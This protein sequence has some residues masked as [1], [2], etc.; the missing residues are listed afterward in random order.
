MIVRI[1]AIITFLFQCVLSFAQIDT[2]LWQ[3]CLGTDDGYNYTNAVEKCAEGYLFGI[4]L[5]NNGPDISNFHGGA[6]SWIVNTD[7]V[8]N[9]IWERCYGGSKGDGPEKIIK[10]DESYFYLLNHSN[11]V[12][13]DILNGRGGNFWVVKINA[14]GNIIWENSFGGSVYGEEVRDAI[15]MPNKGLLLMGRITSS[16]GDVT[17]YYGMADIWFCK[18]D[19][20]GAIEWEKTYGNQGQDNALKL[21]LTSNNTVLMIGGHE[22][23]GGMIDC[24]DPGNDGADVWI[25]QMDLNGNMLNQWCFGGRHHDLGWDIIE[26]ENGYVFAA[27]TNSN[28][29]DVNG[30]HGSEW[31][32]YSDIWVVKI[33]FSGNLIWQ[34]CLGGYSWEYPVYL[35]Q[36]GD[37]GFII[38]GN[39]CS[40]D[41]DVT[42]NHSLY[43]IYADIWV[44]KVNSDGQ[45]EW[46]HCFGGGSVE[47]FF[48]IH[49]VL[50]RDDYNYVL[51]A[52]ADYLDGDVE[53]DLFPNDLQDNAWLLEIKDCNF[54][55]P[56]APA[57]SSGPDT[58]CSINHATSIYSINPVTWSWGYEWSIEPENAGILLQHS[59]IVEITWN[60]QFE[61]PVAITARSYNDCGYSNWS[62][63]HNTWI[64][65]CLGVEENHSG[66]SIFVQPNPA[67]TWVAFNYELTDNSSDGLIKI[68][69]ITGKVIQ[70]FPVSGKIGQKIWDTRSV[71]PGLY[72]YVI[73]VSG[74]SKSGKVII[75]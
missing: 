63:P 13:G 25:L 59:L 38:I 1:S 41:G 52:N 50:K 4:Y 44:V 10:I 3:K 29:G 57:I 60:T 62:E 73:T 64:Y 66:S 37:N 51:G 36:T 24:P 32:E 61:G 6:D 75:H 14:S 46:E 15:L 65:S 18:I 30:F 27:S 5:R 12:D 53:C 31:T 20:L 45:L 49:S 55:F 16:G 58:L 19:S 17:T 21:K 47:R 68:T 8:G 9:I 39:T 69:D 71:K 56:E 28:D 34:K 11:S 43:D 35:T 48:G 70:L 22:E 40:L 42:G 2:I 23:S 54:N 33:D 74:L 26:V 7:S 67:H 72:F